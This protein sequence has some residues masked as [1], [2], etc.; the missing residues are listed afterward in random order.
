VKRGWAVVLGASAGTGSAIARAVA[1]DPGLDVF[2]VHRGHHP[3][4]AAELEA[5]IAASGRRAVLRVDDAGTPEGAI[6][7]AEH[8]L[9]EAG[10]RSVTFF[11]HSIANASLGRLTGRDPVAPRQ[12]QK[13]FDSMAHS[14]VYW[15]QALLERDLLAEGGARLLAL[16]N[17]LDESMLAQCGVIAASKAA[18][19]AYVRYL[20]LEL[21]PRGHRV[22]V[23]KFATVITPAVAKVYG[24]GELARIEAAH[25]EMT[26]AGRMCTTDEVGGFVSL[27]LDERAE[28]LNG[29]TIDFSGAM[30]QSLID[31]LLR[32]R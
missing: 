9:R 8:L 4:S 19:Q 14:F 17:P 26:P 10:P 7:G 15:A 20:A 6:Q 13:T 21:G 22:N 18:L 11:V 1:Q 3:A 16:T 27:L 25:R 5:A 31:V 24:E 2:G 29:A 12:I 32:R 28:W 23:L 30:A